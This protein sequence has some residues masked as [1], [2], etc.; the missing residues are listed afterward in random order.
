[1]NIIHGATERS[2]K[3]KI[4]N[5]ILKRTTRI[6]K[7]TWSV[8]NLRNIRTYVKKFPKIIYWNKLLFWISLL[9]KYQKKNKLIDLDK[10]LTIKI[11][12]I[13]LFTNLIF[14]IFPTKFKL[15]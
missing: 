12:L 6:L 11:I 5:A 1:M 14:L 13:V 2:D 15:N 10:C 4:N 8:N 9:K 7:I 3:E